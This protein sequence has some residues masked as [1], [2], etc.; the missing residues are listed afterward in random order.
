MNGGVPASLPPSIV[1]VAPA[2]KPRSLRAE[3]DNGRGGILGSADPAQRHRARSGLLGS[4]PHPFEIL[5]EDRTGSD[6]VDAHA[7]AC[8]VERRDLGDL[9]LALIEPAWVGKERLGAHAFCAGAEGLAYLAYGTREPGDM[10]STPRA[11]GSRC[12]GWGSH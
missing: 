11:A 5:S 6:R 4:R 2:M 9:R 8:V 7:V 3:P 12:G 1:S 10:S